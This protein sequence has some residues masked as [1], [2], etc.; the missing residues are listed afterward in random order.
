MNIGYR[1]YMPRMKLIGQGNTSEIFE[2]NNNT[3]LKLYRNEMPNDLCVHEFEITKYVYEHLKI[4]PK[5]IEIINIDGRIG[6]VYEKLNGKTMLNMMLLK[7]W[8]ISKYS[9]MLANYHVTIQKN[10]KGDIQTLTVKEKLKQD[11]E[12]VS[13][14]SI[15]EKELIYKYLGALPDGDTICHF[16]FHPDN[17]MVSSNQFYVIDWMTGCVGDPLSD[18]ARTALI[19]NYAEIPRVPFFINAMIGVFQKSVYRI[20]LREYL[21]LTGTDISDIQKWEL[22]IATA[23]LCEWIPKGESRRLVRFIKTRLDVL[24]DKDVK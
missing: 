7:P 1:R 12:S 21:R 15:R 11:I 3:I 13:L 16:D 4:T 14:L 6:A 2:W 22:P 18:I 23:R 17:I 19:L 8:N 5:P 24:T 20:Y 9:K 10:A